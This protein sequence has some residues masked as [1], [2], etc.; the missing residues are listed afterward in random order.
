MASILSEN[1]LSIQIDCE[2]SLCY[3]DSLFLWCVQMVCVCATQ[4]VSLFI[5]LP[6]HIILLNGA[7]LFEV[8]SIKDL[9]VSIDSKL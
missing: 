1:Q 8:S 5:T 4:F 9:G 3:L 2:L 7:P 6:E